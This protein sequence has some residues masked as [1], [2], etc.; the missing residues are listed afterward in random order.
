MAPADIAGIQYFETITN[1][2]MLDDELSMARLMKQKSQPVSQYAYITE[3]HGDN[4]CT[5]KCVYKLETN[6]KFRLQTL[7][8]AMPEGAQINNKLAA[9][10]GAIRSIV[11]HPTVSHKGNWSNWMA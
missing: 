3:P 5:V 7:Q 1:P 9:T 6:E 2:E 10:S 11:Q 4:E 8:R